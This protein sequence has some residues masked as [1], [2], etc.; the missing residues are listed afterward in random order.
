MANNAEIRI[1]R[2]FKN[3]SYNPTMIVMVRDE[4]DRAKYYLDKRVEITKQLTVAYELTR[5]TKF[6]ELMIMFINPNLESEEKINF[7]IKVNKDLLNYNTQGY[8]KA[9]VRDPFIVFNVSGTY[10]IIKFMEKFTLLRNAMQKVVDDYESGNFIEG[11]EEVEV[12][13]NMSPDDIRLFNNKEVYETVKNTAMV[14]Y[15]KDKYNPNG[16][17]GMVMLSESKYGKDGKPFVFTKFCTDFRDGTNFNIGAAIP[18]KDDLN[19]T[20]QPAKAFTGFIEGLESVKDFIKAMDNVINDVDII[21]KD[22]IAG[23]AVDIYA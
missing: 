16:N 9:I 7:C 21:I 8:D 20:V 6:H 4:N 18:N 17:I 15:D 23:T 3:I 5:E 2:K 1:R 14:V 12:T 19:F 13:Y 10:N 22:V 11:A